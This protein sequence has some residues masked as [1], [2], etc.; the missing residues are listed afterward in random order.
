[1]KKSLVHVA[2][3]FWAVLPIVFRKFLLKAHF[4][5][6][7]LTPGDSGVRVLLQCESDY[8]G[9]LGYGAMRIEG[10]IHPKHR[11]MKYHDFFIKNIEDGSTVVDI[12]CG[13]GAVANSVVH[14]KNVHV[15]GIDIVKENVEK[16]NKL[17]EHERLKF[18]VGDA[19][20]VFP[21]DNCDVVILSNVLEHIE[22]RVSFLRRIQ[23]TLNPLKILIRVPVFERNWTVGYKKDLGLDYFSDDT[24]YAEHTQ[25]GWV[26]EIESS[27][28]KVKSKELRWGEIWCECICNPS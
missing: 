28:L 12:G 8:E 2:A 5:L 15:Y 20:K 9:A 18:V 21:A 17:W 23:E 16:A 14:A 3:L 27:G 1:M 22:H 10:G 6:E 25:E 24:H 19:L 13:Y 4:F 11:V 7:G 26:E